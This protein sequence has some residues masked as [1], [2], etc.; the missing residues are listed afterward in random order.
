M[1]PFMQLQQGLAEAWLANKPDSTTDHVVLAMPSFSLGES[2][3]AHYASRIP[4]LEHRCLNAVFLLNS[5]P[6]GEFVFLSTVAPEP[7]VMDCYFSLLPAEKTWKQPLAIA[8][9]WQR[10]CRARGN[11]PWR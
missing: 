2:T 7:E 6:H 9:V 10:Y 11:F 8:G 3:L 4:A 1:I 5:I